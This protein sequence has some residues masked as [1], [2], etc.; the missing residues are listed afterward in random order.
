MQKWMLKVAQVDIGLN[1]MNQDKY[2]EAIRHFTELI[3]RHPDDDEL[4]F[5]RGEVYRSAGR[6][7]QLTTK[8]YSDRIK[9]INTPQSIDYFENS[10]KDYEKALEMHSY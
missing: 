7:S 10:I 2:D 6:F 1:L 9:T 8:S 3:K 5:W 4:Y